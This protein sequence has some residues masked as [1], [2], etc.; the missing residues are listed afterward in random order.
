MRQMVASLRKGGSVWRLFGVVMLIAVV[1]SVIGVGAF[2]QPAQ[3]ALATNPAL[4]AL[5]VTAL[6]LPFAAVDAAFPVFVLVKNPGDRSLDK[7]VI[8]ITVPQGCTLVLPEEN[9]IK[10]YFGIR[11]HGYGFAMWFVECAV[12]GDITISVSVV[13]TI[14]GG[15]VTGSDTV[16]ITVYDI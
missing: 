14:G 15:V 6:A 2:S 4:P 9:E 12:E 8:S 3:A 13:G 16:D 5:K 7:P 1:A 11:Q 10:P